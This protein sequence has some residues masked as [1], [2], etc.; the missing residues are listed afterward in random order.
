M[1]GLARLVL[2]LALLELG[3][4]LVVERIFVN[5]DVKLAGLHLY[6]TTVGTAGCAVVAVAG[7]FD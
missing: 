5:F 6:W 1:L 7:L 3:C 4:A 2:G